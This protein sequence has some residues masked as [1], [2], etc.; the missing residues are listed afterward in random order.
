V[1]NVEPEVASWETELSI[2]TCGGNSVGFITA[3]SLSCRDFAQLRFL[4]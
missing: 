3:F 4:P 1:S 2:Q